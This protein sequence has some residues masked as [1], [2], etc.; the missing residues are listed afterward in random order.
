MHNCIGKQNSSSAHVHGDVALGGRR[1]RIFDVVITS[2]VLVVAAPMLLVTVALIRGLIGKSAI[3][4]KQLVGLEGRVFDAYQFRT[5]VESYGD[6]T[7]SLGDALQAS[8]LDKLPLLLNVLRGDMSLIGPR[9]ITKSELSRYKSQLP[10][11]FTAR[12]GLTGLW[13]RASALT[14][15]NPFDWMVLD[16]HYISSWSVWLDITLLI[17]VLSRGT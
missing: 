16:R 9:P 1:K 11:Y 3:V 6:G 5:T 2:I 7:A 17:K 13:R 15:H 4:V 14:G 12:P 8:G 10:E